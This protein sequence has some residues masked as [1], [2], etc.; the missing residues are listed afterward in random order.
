MFRIEQRLKKSN[1]YDVFAR[2][3][4][5]TRDNK[6]RQ[7]KRKYAPQDLNLGARFDRIN[8]YNY[9][10]VFDA[11]TGEYIPG[12]IPRLL[13]TL[14][15]GRA[16]DDVEYPVRLEEYDKARGKFER[17]CIAD[18]LEKFFQREETQQKKRLYCSK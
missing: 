10:S 3:L 14:G 12:D 7:P 2:M 18:A 6:Y 17:L 13:A 4:E 1:V 8:W 11:K 9:I 5:F 15:S 16:E